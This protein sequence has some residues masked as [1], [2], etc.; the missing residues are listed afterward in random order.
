MVS[1]FASLFASP[2]ANMVIAALAGL[3]LA[4]ACAAAIGYFIARGL[5]DE[6]RADERD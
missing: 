3:A 1:M 5:W 4:G 2:D 6:P